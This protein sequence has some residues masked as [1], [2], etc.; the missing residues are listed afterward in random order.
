MKIVRLGMTESGLL[1]LTFAS[2]HLQLNPEIKKQIS[3]YII[4]LTNWLYTTSGYY[5]KTVPGNKFNFD[6]RALNKNFSDYMGHLADA[7]KDCEETQFYF[8]EGFIKNLYEH[9]KELFLSHYQ[10]SNF[11]LLNDTKFSS[12][13]ANVYSKIANKKVLVISAFDGII[14]SQYNS[15]N[16]YKLGLN[17]PNITSLCTVKTPYCF[18]NNGPHN[19]YFET[20][21]YI[22]DMVVEKDFDIEMEPGLP[23][24]TLSEILIK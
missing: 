23:T 21:N 16:V 4:S 7:V 9:S 18:L 12:R 6:V 11:K 20:L 22:Y 5:D 14:E 2:K 8:H 13:I 1:I 15:G 19:N 24:T 17:F 10:I 3:K